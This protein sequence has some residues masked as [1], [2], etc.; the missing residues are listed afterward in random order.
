MAQKSIR[1]RGRTLMAYESLGIIL[2]VE[3]KPEEAGERILVTFTEDCPDPQCQGE[4]QAVVDLGYVTVDATNQIV[5]GGID[6]QFNLPSMMICTDCGDS[7]ELPEDVGALIA[8]AV[9]QFMQNLPQLRRE[10]QAPWN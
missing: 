7:A 5:L 3:L 10:A 9:A 2:A 8:V 6:A 1:Q 4:F